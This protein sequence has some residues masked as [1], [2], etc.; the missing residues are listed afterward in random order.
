MQQHLLRRGQ[1]R[2]KI[3]GVVI[4]AEKA[5][6]FR[7]AHRENRL[8]EVKNVIQRLQYFPVAAERNDDIGAFHL[9]LTVKLRE[10]LE[11]FLSKRTRRGDEG[12]FQGAGT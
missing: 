10:G 7:T 9:A 5:D 1:A 2:G 11:G 4:V 12:D 3:A 6:R 8:A